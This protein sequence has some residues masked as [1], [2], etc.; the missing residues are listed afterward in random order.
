MY[1]HTF[2]YVLKVKCLPS[3]DD[4]PILGRSPSLCGVQQLKV[5]WSVTGR[6]LWRGVGGTVVLRG[7]RITCQCYLSHNCHFH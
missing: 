5:L 3:H 1:T 4:G 6:F 7:V 2:V